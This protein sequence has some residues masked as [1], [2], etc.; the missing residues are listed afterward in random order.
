MY[1]SHWGLRESPFRSSGHDKHHFASR[2]HEEAQAR[3]LY[4]LRGGR[5]MMLL[6]G[7]TGHGVTYACEHYARGS[8]GREFGATAKDAS[9]ALEAIAEVGEAPAAGRP[10]DQ[11]VR[12]QSAMASPVLL[13]DEAHLAA[14]PAKEVMRQLCD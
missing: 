13:W 14:S 3:M 10:Y 1:E 4:A 7:R 12:T 11:V 5:G 2:A 9:V 8:E 6:T